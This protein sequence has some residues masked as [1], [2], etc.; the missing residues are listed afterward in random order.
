MLADAFQW[1]APPERRRQPGLAAP[2]FRIFPQIA[3]TAA[4]AAAAFCWAFFCQ[5]GKR[6]L[7]FF[8]SFIGF[9]EIVCGGAGAGSTPAMDAILP[10]AAPIAFAVVVKILSSVAGSVAFL[11]SLRSLGF[12]WSAIIPSQ[13][14][15]HACG[16]L[17][18]PFFQPIYYKIT[19]TT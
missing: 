19:A 8:W 15:Q 6:C 14:D 1:V 11:R 5:R 16:H 10:A 9:V 2:L 17:P 13:S 7:F 18:R 3:Q 4:W 12:C